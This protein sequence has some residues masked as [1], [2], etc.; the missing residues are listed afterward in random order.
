MSTDATVATVGAAHRRTGEMF[1]RL[2]PALPFALVLIIWTGSWAIF[3]PNKATLPPVTDVI[4]AVWTRAADGELL[5]HILASLWRLFLGATVGVSTGILCGF[6][7]GLYRGVSEFLNPLVVFFNAISGIVWLPLMIGWLGIGT[8]LAVFLIWNTVFFIV[9]Q[10]T[11]LGVQLVPEVY[12]QGVQSLGGNRL[13]TIRSVILPGALPYILTGIR[14]G[15]GF[16]WRALIAAELVGTPDG[17]GQM[18]FAAA[19]YHRSDIIIAGCLIIGTIAIFMDRWLLLPIERRTV[20]RWG[21]LAVATEEN[22]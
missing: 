12:E 2:L 8:A 10:N 3:H 20:E 22:P 7:A 13:E 21:L 18:I 1:R 15:L 11:V 14:S 9:F 4:A 19:D 16:G 5:R 6:V 17:L